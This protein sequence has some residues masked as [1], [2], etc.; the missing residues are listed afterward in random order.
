MAKGEGAAVHDFV[1][2]LGEQFARVGQQ[3][4]AGRVLGW[5]LVCD[6]PEQ[7]AGELA[8]VTGASKASI[9]IAVR[10]LTAAG[11]VERVGVAG[12][13]QTHY[14]LRPTCWTTDVRQKLDVM[15][16]MREI[17]ERGLDA[18][19]GAPKARRQRLQDMR[20]FYA[21]FEQEFPAAIERWLASRG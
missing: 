10:L 20:D 1:E 18:L 17:A 2:Q 21:F 12:K 6:P 4:I 11:M 9:S 19:R 8:E 5:L 7:S 13:R 16:S 15:R 14:R 3:R